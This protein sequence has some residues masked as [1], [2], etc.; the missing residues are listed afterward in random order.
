MRRYTQEQ[1]AFIR[2]N[3]GGITTRELAAMV[4]KQFG[5]ICTESQMRAYK[6]NH[7]LR[8][9]TP[10]GIPADSPTKLYPAGVREFIRSNYKG[11]GHRA[12]ADLLNA[13]FGTR[14]TKGQM[15]SIYS[16]W[17]LNSG[18]LGRFPK[19]HIPANK[20]KKGFSYP[21][22]VKTQFKKGHV[23]HNWLPVGRERITRDGYTEVKIAEPNIW[24]LKHRLVWEEHN[25]PIS[26]GCAIVFLDQN[27]QNFAIEN[28][29]MLQRR[30]LSILNKKRLLHTNAEAS[31]TG[32]LL[33]EVIIKMSDRKGRTKKAKRKG[34]T[35]HG[36][37]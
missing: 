1:H 7:R 16:R 11:V 34:A 15:K 24:K 27:K 9:G 21:G 10:R 22:M 13:K 12:M 20:G 4:N 5:E 17:K 33:A 29:Q 18:L 30:Q 36:A 2:E 31:K 26:K 28:L 8:S 23:P 6:T 14:Y 35:E 3:A 32:I 25:G 19:G 37:V